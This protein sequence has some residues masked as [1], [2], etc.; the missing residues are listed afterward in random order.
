MVRYDIGAAMT[1][2]IISVNFRLL[3]DKNSAL[4]RLAKIKLN[5]VATADV[6]SGVLNSQLSDEDLD[7]IMMR[8]VLC[9]D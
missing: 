6:R 1:N 5:T 7:V 8:K 9:H 4:M 3:G 2:V